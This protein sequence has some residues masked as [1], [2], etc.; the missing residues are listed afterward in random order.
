MNTAQRLMSNAAGGQILIAESTAGKLRRGFDL[1]RL[2]E[3]KVKGKSEAVP[4]FSV[5]WDDKPATVSI[6]SKKKRRP[7]RGARQS[8]KVPI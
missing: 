3:M 8:R 7:T 4:V 2:P 1:K 6:S 5:G